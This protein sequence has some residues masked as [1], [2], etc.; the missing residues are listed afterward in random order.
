MNPYLRMLFPTLVRLGFEFRYQEDCPDILGDRLFITYPGTRF[1]FVYEIKSSAIVN[2]NAQQL[3]V[4]EMQ[5]INEIKAHF[6][7]A[8]KKY[9]YPSI[10]NRLYFKSM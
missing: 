7:K 9:D 8:A 2:M 1:E 3:D 6:E 4:L 10:Y 5:I